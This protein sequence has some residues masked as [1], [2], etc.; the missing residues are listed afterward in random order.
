VGEE[1]SVPDNSHVAAMF[2]REQR[3]RSRRATF[4]GRAL[5]S[6]GGEDGGE[7]AVKLISFVVEL[8]TVR[9]DSDCDERDHATTAPAVAGGDQGMHAS[10]GMASR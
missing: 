10:A 4:E 7:P 1:V 5:T 3:V 8:P 2:N 9:P 6:V